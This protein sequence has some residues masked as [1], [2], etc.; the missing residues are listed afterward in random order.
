MKVLLLTSNYPPV[1]GGVSRY[2]Q[3]LVECAEGD[4]GV[5]GI[6]LGP[7]VPDSGRALKNRILQ[8]RWAYTVSKNAPKSVV[9]LAGQPHLALGAWA[10]RRKFSVALHGGEWEDYFFGNKFLQKVMN[11]STQILTSSVATA[12]EWVS[13]ANRNKTQSVTPGLP[14]FGVMLLETS[15][16]RESARDKDSTFE[17]LSVSR[18]SPRKGI[19]K[20][21]DAIQICRSRGLNVNLSVIGQEQG[22]IHTDESL[23]GI[24]FL[25]HV[26]DEELAN[27]YARA[28]AFALLPERIQGGEGWE[29]FG[30]VYLEAAAAGLPVIATDTGGV[31]EAV[32]ADGAIVLKADC[33][34]ATI[35]KEIKNL[36]VDGSKQE[37]MSKANQKWANVNRWEAK[38]TQVKAVIDQIAASSDR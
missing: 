1:S 19:Q 4:I 3:G 12:N 34:S 38:K 23:G 22:T 35:A 27:H 10:A 16:T 14:D 33:T 6:D 9:I 20:L 36:I 2:Y 8:I 25:G 28:Q 24:K 31:L 30:I 7:A 29:G 15:V 21:V 37:K 18:A 26:S 5:A 13:A 32:C 11:S 17:F